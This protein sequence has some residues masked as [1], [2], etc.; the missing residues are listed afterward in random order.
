MRHNSENT[1][2]WPDTLL[3]FYFLDFKTPYQYV[4]IILGTANDDHNSEVLTG[5]APEGVNCYTCNRYFKDHNSDIQIAVD[6]QSRTLTMSIA[7][8]LRYA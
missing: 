8:R 3:L 5:V 7:T 6:S 4:Y 2:L 1:R